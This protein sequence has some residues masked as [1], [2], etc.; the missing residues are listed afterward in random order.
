MNPG[1]YKQNQPLWGASW[2]IHRRRACTCAQGPLW[3]QE[4]G[5]PGPCFAQALVTTRFFN[6]FYHHKNS[7]DFLSP[8]AILLS[9]PK[10]WTFPSGNLLEKSKTHSRVTNSPSSSL[11]LFET[12]QSG[13]FFYVA[14]YVLQCLYFIT[15][16]ACL[17]IYV[18]R[19]HLE[20]YIRL[21][22]PIILVTFMVIG[23]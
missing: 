20:L 15:H 22:F 5:R 17:C 14:T 12:R 19:S 11:S 18:I 4:R 16:W 8:K 21:S 3:H 13:V 9:S 7:H 23:R 10:S 6:S 1:Q 2:S